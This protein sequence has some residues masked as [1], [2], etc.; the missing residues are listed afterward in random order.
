MQRTTRLQAILLRPR[1]I[2]YQVVPSSI[3]SLFYRA[4]GTNAAIGNAT[5]PTTRIDPSKLALQPGQTELRLRPPQVGT[6][7]FIKYYYTGFIAGINGLVVD[8]ANTVG[9]PTA[10]DFQFRTWNGSQW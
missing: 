10:S 8:I 1:R 4:I 2:F 6:A 7:N 9:I 5:N 3:L